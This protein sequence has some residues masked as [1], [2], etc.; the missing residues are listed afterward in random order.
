MISNLFFLN[1]SPLK[2]ISVLHILIEFSASLKNLS[3][4]LLLKLKL[5]SKESIIPSSIRTLFFN[6]KGRIKEEQ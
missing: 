4:T 2:V 3:L 5:E 1:S 6:I